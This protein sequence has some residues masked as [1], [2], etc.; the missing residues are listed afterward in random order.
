MGDPSLLGSGEFLAGDCG[1]YLT[2]TDT[3]TPRLDARADRQESLAI[4]ASDHTRSL[5]TRLLLGAP[6]WPKE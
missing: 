5:V 3:Q 6:S 4:P 2:G 1:D